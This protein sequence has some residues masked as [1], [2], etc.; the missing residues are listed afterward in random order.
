L[1]SADSVGEVFNIGNPREVE[2]T[3]GL[4]RRITALVPGT[5]IQMQA[6]ERAECRARIPSIDKARKLLGF[7]PKVDLDEGLRVTLEWFRGG[8]P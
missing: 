7:E 8:D 4:A 2:T 3:L 5:S 6:D 1:N